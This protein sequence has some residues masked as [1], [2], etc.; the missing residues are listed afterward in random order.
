MARFPIR[1]PAEE[2]T[3]HETGLGRKRN[4]GG[5]ADD[6]AK[7]QADH[8]AEPDGGSDPHVREGSVAHQRCQLRAGL[9]EPVRVTPQRGRG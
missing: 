2:R 4:I 9:F 5:D 1:E 3:E 8:G 6:D 7:R